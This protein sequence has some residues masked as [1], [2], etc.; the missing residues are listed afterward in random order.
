M[1]LLPGVKAHRG[2]AEEG[3]L[4][5]R[6]GHGPVCTHVSFSVLPSQPAEQQPLYGTS[7]SLASAPLWAPAVREAAK[8]WW[9]SG[10]DPWH[11]GGSW[12]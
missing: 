4:H 12:R 9:S 10:C 8:T 11:P 1:P 3:M 7:T 6:A 2:K 5:S